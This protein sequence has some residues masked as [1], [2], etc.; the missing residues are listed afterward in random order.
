MNGKRNLRINLL[1]NF[2]HLKLLTSFFE[3]STMQY[4]RTKINTLISSIY[5]SVIIKLEY[6]ER[7]VQTEK[8]RRIA[9]LYSKRIQLCCN[10]TNKVKELENQDFKATYFPL[11][12][13]ELDSVSSAKKYHCLLKS[14]ALL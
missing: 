11:S 1:L 10:N 4:H 12:A 8:L 3:I 7:H 9:V 2:E 13:L 14:Q 6:L 5:I